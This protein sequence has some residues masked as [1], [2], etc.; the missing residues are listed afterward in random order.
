MA[1]SNLIELIKA[2][3][4]RTGAGMM[5]CKRALEANG[6]D[7]E[8]AVDHLREKGVIKAANKSTRIAAEGLTNVALSADGK[9]AVILEVNCETD[10]VSSSD[11]FHGLVDKVT[12]VLLAKE[13][14][15]LEEAK[16][17]TAIPF[18]DATVAMGEKFDLRRYEVVT[19]AEG[20]G[21]STYMHMG[22]KISVLVVFDK[23]PGEY[24][25]PLAMHI[26]ANNPSYIALADVP[27]D[28]RA[29]EKAIAVE[30]V[31]A[32]PKLTSKPDAVKAQIVERK[33]DK[34]LSGSCLSLQN[35]LLD[36]SK[37]VGTFLTEKGLGIVSFVRYQV[38]EGI[39]KRQQ[40]N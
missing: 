30:E 7:I 32:D 17:L 22:G 27:A 29:R 4:E 6:L 20:Q 10:F 25:K 3:R 23:D 21:F 18:T 36:E 31:K 9:K 33:V 13:P 26:A 14:K 1:D 38:G 34:T 35:Y 15:T 37:T 16:E 39:A 24:A 8:K 2:L 12:E 5:D 19:L 11:K 40:E 28:I